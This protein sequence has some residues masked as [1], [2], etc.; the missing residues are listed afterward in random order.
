MRKGGHKRKK[1]MEKKKGQV[2]DL[3]RGYRVSHWDQGLREGAHVLHKEK[4]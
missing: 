2:S 3:T 4:G 1:E